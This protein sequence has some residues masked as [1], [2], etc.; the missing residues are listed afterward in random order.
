MVSFKKKWG[1]FR[2]QVLIYLFNWV[3]IYL[4]IS[5]RPGGKVGK[6]F[7][8]ILAKRLFLSCGQGVNVEHGAFIEQPWRLEIGD[9]SG[10]GVNSYVDGPVKIGE[11]VMMGPQVTIYRR[12]HNTSKVDVPMSEQG[13]GSFVPLEIE[14]DVWI[15]GHVIIL[16]SVKKIGKGSVV[17]A[18]AVLV[19]DALPFEVIAGNPGC[20][21]KSRNNCKE[22]S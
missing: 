22:A 3:A 15:G 14:D 12:N 1:S 19:K 18:G 4:P 6:W 10:I 5:Y 7:R 11:Q 16:P 13:F 17:A 8:A 2:Y 20:V 9:G 21:I